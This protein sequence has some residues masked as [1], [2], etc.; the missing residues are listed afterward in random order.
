MKSTPNVLL[1]TMLLG[2]LIACTDPTT[3]PNRRGVP[4]S[5]AFC[6]G[7]PPPP[8]ADG[9]FESLQFGCIIPPGT[10]P[11]TVVECGPTSLPPSLEAV[12]FFNPSRTNGFIDFSSSDP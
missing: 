11:G 12:I 9:E 3:G 4:A 6:V 2:A 1:G 8:P 7:D 10:P 5:V